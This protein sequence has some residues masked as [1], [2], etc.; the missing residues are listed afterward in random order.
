MATRSKYDNL[1]GKVRLLCLKTVFYGLIYL[2]YNNIYID[3]AFDCFILF[4]KDNQPDV[5][6]TPDVD[7]N[8]NQNEDE[9]VRFFLTT[10]RQFKQLLHNTKKLKI[11]YLLI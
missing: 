2:Y 8:S 1:P 10:Q 9:S 5:F 6:E 4:K 7:N 11:L 3:F